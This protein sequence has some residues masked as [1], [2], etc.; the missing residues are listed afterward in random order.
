MLLQPLPCFPSVQLL[1]F[2]PFMALTATAQSAFPREWDDVIVPA[3]RQRLKDESNVLAKRISTTSIVSGD[4][5]P[6]DL[7]PSNS[8]YSSPGHETST[9]SHY[10]YSKPSAIPRPSLQQSRPYD[11][12]AGSAGKP[13]SIRARTLS[14]P[15]PFDESNHADLT[16]PSM[17]ASRPISPATST[18]GTRIPI[19]RA[20]AGST[21]SQA[22]TSFHGSVGRTNGSIYTRY[23]GDISTDSPNLYPVDE[24]HQPHPARS[25][26]RT[27]TEF[28]ESLPERMSSDSEE[29]PFEHW[30]RGRR[31]EMLDI[32][33]YGH[34]F[35]KASARV[36]PDGN[37]R[38]RSTSRGKDVRRVRARA[39]SVGTAV[40]ARESIYIDDDERARDA[41]M[42]LDEQ[43]LTD[44]DS[45]SYEDE[46]PA[47]DPY[48]RQEVT[49]HP[50]GTIS[51]PAFDRSATPTSVRSRQAKNGISQSR[52][53]TPTHRT[54]H[55]AHPRRRGLWRGIRAWHFFAALKSNPPVQFTPS[56]CPSGNW[57][58]VVLPVVA[59]KK[60]LEGHYE[61]ADGSRARSRRPMFTSRPQ[62]H[63]D[64]I[65]LNIDRQEKVWNQKIYLWMSSARKHSWP[66]IPL[67]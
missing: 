15:F 41:R 35:R 43:P 38:S 58:D 24:H 32:A 61:K 51:S 49:P 22:Q 65:I 64:T 50:Y 25:T 3:L 21:S 47:E 10:Y 48:E 31:Q 30:Y 20:R 9:P 54:L 27:P 28:D 40:G 66:K 36:V 6:S 46:D 26:A 14:Q 42:V 34:T 37:S 16:A 5:H 67:F 18:K 56:D 12:T 23:N 8:P 53:P 33:N 29:R 7:Y 13:T 17:E 52:I 4:D 59:R 19:S 11:L 60:G 2:I 55:H 62:A 45:D 1:P 44:L 39:E 63:S 57:D